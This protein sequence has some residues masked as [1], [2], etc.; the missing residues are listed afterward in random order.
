M[1]IQIILILCYKNDLDTKIE[2]FALDS[3]LFFWAFLTNYYQYSGLNNSNVL[4]HSFVVNSD[5]GLI[6]LKS[7]CLQTPFLSRGSGEECFPAHLGCL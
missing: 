3:V 7:K 1:I 4:F 6:V 2:Y 5:T